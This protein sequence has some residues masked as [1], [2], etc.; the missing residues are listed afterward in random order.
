MRRFVL[1]ALLLAPCGAAQALTDEIQV[2]TG[3]IAAPV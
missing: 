1:A 2:Y 3:D